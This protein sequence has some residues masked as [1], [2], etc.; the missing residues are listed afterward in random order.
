MNEWQIKIHYSIE[1]IGYLL[2]MTRRLN[3]AV[4][5]MCGDGNIRTVKTGAIGT[6]QLWLARFDDLG[7]LRQLIEEAEKQGVQS[8]SAEHI[9]GELTA[10][11]SHLEDM[12]KLVFRRA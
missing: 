1:H 10:T 8:P 6:G 11:K 12:R 3:G 2:Y 5:F 9:A 4:E 7:Q